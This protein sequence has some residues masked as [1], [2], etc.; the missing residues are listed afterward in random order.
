[1]LPAPVDTKSSSAWLHR[2][3]AF[4][5]EPLTVVAAEFNRYAATPIKIETHP[6]RSYRSVV[7]FAPTIRSRSWRSCAL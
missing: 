6:F 3:M 4:K 7:Y 2:Q 1:M 5:R